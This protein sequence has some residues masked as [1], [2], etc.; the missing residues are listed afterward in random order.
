MNSRNFDLTHSKPGKAAGPASTVPNSGLSNTQ[1]NVL[2]ANG[3]L[4]SNTIL[5]NPANGNKN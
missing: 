1:P 5:I 3:G 2:G 4:Q